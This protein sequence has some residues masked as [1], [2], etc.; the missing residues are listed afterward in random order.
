MDTLSTLGFR[1]L[2]CA[3]I[4]SSGRARA[5]PSG[6]RGA[7]GR[8]PG[9]SGGA[10]GWIPARER[11][12]ERKGG[13]GGGGGGGEGEGARGR[14]G[15]GRR[16]RARERRKR[17]PGPCRRPGGPA[18]RAGPAPPAPSPPPRSSARGGAPSP[19]L[20]ATRRARPP[21]T[22]FGFHPSYLSYAPPVASTVRRR[23]N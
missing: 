3:A 22:T 17:G 20:P 2:S 21:G 18:V 9:R 13:G 19:P 15:R 11:Q 1:I 10:A 6:A 5:D 8:R 16:E 4:A 7:G 14:R 23:G 12:T